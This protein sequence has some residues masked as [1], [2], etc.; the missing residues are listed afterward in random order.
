MLNI[1]QE[2]SFTEGEKREMS[3]APKNQKLFDEPSTSRSYRDIESASV[4]VSF[5]FHAH[6]VSRHVSNAEMITN[7]II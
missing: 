3:C 2:Y 1:F 5:K 4:V 7:L 6:H